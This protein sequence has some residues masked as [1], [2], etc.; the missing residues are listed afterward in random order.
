MATATPE[1][2][3]RP[4]IGRADHGRRVPFEDF[5][6]AEFEGHPS[7]YELARGVVVVTDTAG[8]T[9][10]RIVERLVELFVLYKL[11]HP[12][13]I[14]LRAG[15]GECRLRLPGMQSDRHPDQ[16]LYLLPPPEIE[17]PWTRWIP[18]IVVEVLSPGGEARDLIEKREEYLLRGAIEY[19]V[20]DPDSRQMLSL[21]RVED[22]WEEALIATD[23]AYRTPLLP[24]FEL[25]PADL[26][27]NL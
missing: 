17:Q 25:R 26:F 14:K 21:R 13:I 6:T 16:A 4:R 2:R 3:R 22:S 11:A 7:L 20:I 1:T 15:G 12:G 10:A 24:G 9:H 23:Q 27:G 19:R 8:L 18:Q 5:I